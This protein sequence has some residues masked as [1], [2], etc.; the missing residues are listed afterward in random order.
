LTKEK[1]IKKTVDE[2]VEE[3][4]VVVGGVFKSFGCFLC[5]RLTS[6]IVIRCIRLACPEI[7]ITGIDR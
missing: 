5:K 6:S 1:R 4:D 2:E 3:V 7:Y